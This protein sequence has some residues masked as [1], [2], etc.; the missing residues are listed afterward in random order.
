MFDKGVEE[1]KLSKESDG[2]YPLKIFIEKEGREMDQTHVSCASFTGRPIL[3]Y[4]ATWEVPSFSLI[5][6]G[7]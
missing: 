7:K 6:T 5:T 4:C 2:I 1:E 3:Y